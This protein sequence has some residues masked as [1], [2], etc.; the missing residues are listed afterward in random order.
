[1]EWF[2]YYPNLLSLVKIV[3][4]YYL[5]DLLR[6]VVQLLPYEEALYKTNRMFSWYMVVTLSTSFIQS[7]LMNLSMN[8][9]IP[10][11]IIVIVASFIIEIAFL[12][13]LRNIQK[14]FPKDSVIEK[15]V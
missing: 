11:I 2:K 7:F 15:F 8:T 12:V 13:Y 4:V 5:F 10:L 3:L 9:S 1:M 14:Q 6:A